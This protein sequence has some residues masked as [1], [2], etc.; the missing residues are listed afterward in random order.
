MLENLSWPV[1][2]Y[3]L[4]YGVFIGI[5]G[6]YERGVDKGSQRHGNPLI[7]LGAMAATAIG[8]MALPLVYAFTPLLDRFSYAHHT[9][10][11]AAGAA[12]MVLAL[13]LFARAHRE[14][15]ANFSRNLEIHAGHRLVTSGPYALVRHPIYSAI[16]LFV[17]AQALLLPNLLAGLSGLAGFGALYLLRIGAEE[18]ML[19]QHFGAEYLNWAKTTGRVV[20]RLGW[21]AD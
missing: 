17:A 2:I 8:V 6:F 12:V 5:R 18:R 21:G 15:G 4:G 20:P 1:A 13:Y 3:L 9:G 11:S 7:E 16:W 14:L 10:Q 19:A